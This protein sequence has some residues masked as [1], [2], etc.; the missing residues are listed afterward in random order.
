MKMSTSALLKKNCAAYQLRRTSY[1]CLWQN[2]CLESPPH[3]LVGTLY[4]KASLIAWQDIRNRCPIVS[5]DYKDAY[6]VN[7]YL[8][9]IM[10]SICC[11]STA[12]TEEDRTHS[13]SAAA[14]FYLPITVSTQREQRYLILQ[15]QHNVSTT[16]MSQ[17]ISSFGVYTV[18][19][20]QPRY[21][22]A[23]S[24]PA[25]TR[26]WELEHVKFLDVFSIDLKDSETME[27]SICHDLQTLL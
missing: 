22:P 3:L 14:G 9:T 26:Q 16:I 2:H 10:S 15:T 1:T 25:P 27:P 6:Q 23:A 11:I 21:G 8:S 13:P 24:T 17:E 18:L 5:M 7:M 12:N 4:I 20:H 19:L